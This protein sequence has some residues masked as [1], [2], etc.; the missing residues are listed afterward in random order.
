MTENAAAALSQVNQA[1]GEVTMLSRADAPDGEIAFAI[2]PVSEKELAEKLTLI[3]D[4]EIK[5][6]IRITDY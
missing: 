2:S 3:K 1:F 6:V 4:A 5:S